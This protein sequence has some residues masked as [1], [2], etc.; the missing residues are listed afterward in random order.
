M[1]F[2]VYLRPKLHPDSSK[3]GSGLDR[4]NL[5]FLDTV[6][7]GDSDVE[8]FMKNFVQAKKL[9]NAELSSEVNNLWQKKDLNTLPAFHYEAKLRK[10]KTN[11]DNQ[12]DSERYLKDLRAV[13]KNLTKANVNTQLG[14]LGLTAGNLGGALALLAAYEDEPK[15]KVKN[16]INQVKQKYNL[17]TKVEFE[18][19]VMNAYFDPMTNEVHT[20]YNTATAG[21]ELGHAANAEWYK[22]VFKD[23]ALTAQTVAYARA[24][25]VLPRPVRPFSGP[26]NYLPILTAPAALSLSDT[27]MNTIKGGDPTS[28]RYK[29]GD[30]VYNNPD[31]V[32]GAAGTPILLEEGI[33]SGRALTNMYKFAPEGEKIKEVIK[34][35]KNLGPAFATYATIGAI[36]VAVGYLKKQHRKHKLDESKYKM[37]KMQ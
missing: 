2:N 32:L 11:A 18:P 24:S 33:A 23:K 13:N 16:F 17:T 19:N 20:P 8:R 9:S 10:L 5:R 35:A 12:F 14:I 21:H 25:S 36:P 26:L 34:G 15:T 37:P 1:E 4:N 29:A 31:I 7:A 3:T 30:W 27:A 28:M 6:F 22:R